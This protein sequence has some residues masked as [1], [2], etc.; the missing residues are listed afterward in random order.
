[1]SGAGVAADQRI[2]TTTMIVALFIGV[3]VVV[4]SLPQA[5]QN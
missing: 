4:C 3:V 2:A 1:M 5:A